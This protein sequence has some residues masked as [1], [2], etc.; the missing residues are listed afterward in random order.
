VFIGGGGGGGGGGFGGGGDLPYS[1]SWKS[2]EVG[3]QTMLVYVFE[4]CSFVV[5]MFYVV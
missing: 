2:L 3:C 5:R 1:P 4:M